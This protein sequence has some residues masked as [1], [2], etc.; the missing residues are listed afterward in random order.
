MLSK[1]SSNSNNDYQRNKNYVEKPEV[2]STNK[3]VTFRNKAPKV[4]EKA[5]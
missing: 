5:K 1:P 4:F 2:S 3:N